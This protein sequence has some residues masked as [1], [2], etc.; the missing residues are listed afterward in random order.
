[1]KI[2]F[3]CEKPKQVNWKKASDFL[4]L[5]NKKTEIFIAVKSKKEFL[6]WK[7]KINVK[8]IVLIPWVLLPRERGYWFS[9]FSSKKDIKSLDQFKRYKVFIDA[10]PPI[11]KIDKPLFKYGLYH[12]GLLFHNSKNFNLLEKEVENLCKN[13]KVLYSEFPFPHLLFRRLGIYIN[14]RDSRYNNN[15]EKVLGWYTTFFGSGFRDLIKPY[16]KHK[17]RQAISYYGANNVSFAVGLIGKGLTPNIEHVYQSSDQLDEDL[18]DLKKL[19]AKK[20]ILY[21]IESL[22]KKKDL[23]DWKKILKRYH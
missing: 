19:G 5:I 13:S 15:L 3:W 23:V 11:S 22:M 17:A 21:S 14:A 10:E 1:M 7:K 4:R 2:S 9:G 8:N 20:V 12:L 18:V 6:N 16:L